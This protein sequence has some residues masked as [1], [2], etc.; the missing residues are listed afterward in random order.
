M[1][2]VAESALSPAERLMLLDDV[3][4]SV[5]VD[6]EPIGDYMVF[7][8]GLRTERSAAVLEE[9]L[10]QLT[11]IYN[12]LVSGAD[13]ESYELWV[14]RLF[15]PMAQDVGWEAKPGESED[16]VKLRADLMTVL[17]GV[18]RDPQVQA[19]AQKLASQYLADPDSVDPEIVSVALRVA[20]RLGDET[21]YDKIVQDLRNPK[22]PETYLNEIN[23]LSKFTEPKLVERTLEYAISPQIRSQDAVV[24]IY[25]VMQNH[26]AAKQAWNFVQA[27]WSGIENLGGPFAGGLIV[28]ATG[29]FC[30]PGM[31]DEVQAFFTSHSA[32]A[33]ERSLKQSA[34]QINYCVDRKTLQRDQLASWLQRRS[35]SRTQ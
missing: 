17:G 14:R 35:A 3:W 21:F 25:I 34:E 27:H 5:A 6:R 7:A 8:E 4:A 11:Y 24:L 13:R 10:K 29:N 33:A 22:T 19:L 31:R 2:K 12:Y 18:A 23:T 20:A 30:D 32:P 1:A 16:L 15:T 26:D 9:V 28:Q